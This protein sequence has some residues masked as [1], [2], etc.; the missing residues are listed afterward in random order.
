MK[1][2]L[3]VLG[4][5]VI[6]AAVAPVASADFDISGWGIVQGISADKKIVGGTQSVSEN[7]YFT[8]SILRFIVKGGGEKANV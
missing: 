2:L 8:N 3:I 7:P 5:I 1:K 6:I 4:A